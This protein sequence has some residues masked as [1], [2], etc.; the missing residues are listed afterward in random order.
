MAVFVLVAGLALL[1]CQAAPVTPEAVAPT[2]PA[3]SATI[4]Q[5]PSATATPPATATPAPT[6]TS[7]EAPL[8]DT[9]TPAIGSTPTSTPIAVSPSP[10]LPA[11][12]TIVSEFYIE[13]LPAAAR[14]PSA[15]GRLG[16]RFYVV[17]RTDNCVAVIENQ[18]M[19]TCIPVGDDP[20]ALAVNQALDAGVCGQ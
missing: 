10:T 19:A 16:D 13:G 9:S 14:Q 5:L 3:P 6:L 7:T 18:R 17:S 1:A 2:T 12:P 15:M 8:T 4:E 11:R 20:G